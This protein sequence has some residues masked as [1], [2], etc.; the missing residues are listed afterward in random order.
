MGPNS[1]QF[2]N[3]LRYFQLIWK[4]VYPVLFHSLIHSC[5]DNPSCFQGA[6]P[7]VDLYTEC[8]IYYLCDSDDLC[9]ITEAQF[10][11]M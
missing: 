6:R 10:S 8:R 11:R 7:R 4:I 3:T 5:P 9:I 1:L 2:L